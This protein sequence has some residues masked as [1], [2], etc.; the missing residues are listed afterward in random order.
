MYRAGK[1]QIGSRDITCDDALEMI[2]NSVFSCC[3][4]GG[5]VYRVYYD[6]NGV[7][8]SVEIDCRY[9]G[10]SSFRD[11]CSRK[12]REFSEKYFNDENYLKCLSH[13]FMRNRLDKCIGKEISCIQLEMEKYRKEREKKQEKY[14]QENKNWLAFKELY[15]DYI[16]GV[17]KVIDV[18]PAGFSVRVLFKTDVSFQERKAFIRE[19]GRELMKY[20]ISELKENKKALKSIGDM[21]F[22]MPVMITVLRV[23]EAEVKFEVKRD[24]A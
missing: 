5:M 10:G 23:C 1:I 18:Y 24:I 9:W 12:K 7:L 15:G 19:N 11:L 13:E 2:K 3:L 8:N 17:D 21:S 16:I 20:V 22:Y 4:R 14:L 6:D